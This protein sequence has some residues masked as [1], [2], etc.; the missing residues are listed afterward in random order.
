MVPMS[1]PFTP[2]GILDEPAAE[3]MVAR[4][5]GHGLGVFV[6]G[7]TGEALSIPAAQRERLVTLAL[8][9]AGGRVPVYAGISANCAADSVARARAYL[10][11]GVDAVVAALPSYYLLESAEISAYFELLARE[12]HG[13]LLLYN[14][15][16]TTRMSIPLD[17]I[18]RVSALPN[19]VGLKDSENT[20]DRITA[21]ARRF[22]G[23]PNFSLFMGVS[24]LSVRALRLGYHGLVPSSANLAPALW[25]ELYAHAAAG[26]WPQAEAAQKR[27]DAVARLFQHNRTLGQSLAALKAAL[28]AQGLCHPVVLPPLLTLDAAGCAAIRHEADRL[29]LL[30]EGNGHAAPPVPQHRG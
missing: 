19:V 20:H 18:E 8:A 4:L 11:L 29:G 14:I 2:A 10:R 23:R 28:A 21:V 30:A 5:A 12:I 22:A 1:T 27:L 16:Q 25:H 13:P 7:T 15:P 3:R 6:L 17:V 9:A 24:S 26:E